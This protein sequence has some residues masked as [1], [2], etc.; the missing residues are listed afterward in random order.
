MVPELRELCPQREVAGHE[1]LCPALAVELHEGE[2]LVVVLLLGAL[3]LVPGYKQQYRE[4]L[5]CMF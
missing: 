5:F 3:Q 2:A 4:D 1:E